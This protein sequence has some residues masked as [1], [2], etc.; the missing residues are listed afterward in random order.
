MQHGQPN[1]APLLESHSSIGQGG[2]STLLPHRKQP[3]KHKRKHHTHHHLNR[4]DCGNANRVPIRRGP[5]HH[6][7][8][9][10]GVVFVFIAVLLPHATAIPNY[11]VN[12]YGCRLTKSLGSW[13]TQMKLDTPSIDGKVF[14]QNNTLRF[15]CPQE[16]G[17]L[18]RTNQT[19]LINGWKTYTKC[20]DVYSLNTY[21]GKL[22]TVSDFPLKVEYMCLTHKAKHW[23]AGSF[24][25]NQTHHV[26]STS[27]FAA[28]F[29]AGAYTSE[30]NYRS[31][32]YS[33][34]SIVIA[35]CVGLLS[36]IAPEKSIQRKATIFISVS[37]VFAAFVGLT[38][39]IAQIRK[40]EPRPYSGRLIHSVLGYI[41]ITIIPFTLILGAIQFYNKAFSA[42]FKIMV[43]AMLILT[44]AASTIALIG[45]YDLDPGF[46][47]SLAVVIS[48]YF[49]SSM[50]INNTA[51]KVAE[52]FK[53]GLEDETKGLIQ[54]TE[55]SRR[56]TR[57]KRTFF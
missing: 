45:F 9:T 11:Y 23:Y 27:T 55:G 7:T 12:G 16:Y 3:G 54:T 15:Q 10:L 21:N 28:S 38:V 33:A 17:I 48:I 22:M 6:S 47:I 32:Q 2:R 1:S 52:E 20:P 42:L 39:A 41:T 34:L 50:L 37:L 4:L 46:C 14:V 43:T 36:V 57:K 49:I 25:V 30:N 53:N 51:I 5:S 35:G 13:A 24:I 29:F 40:G 26:E 8:F 19:G 44:V 56:S 18:V 31:M